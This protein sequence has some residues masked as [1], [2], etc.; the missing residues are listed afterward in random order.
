MQALQK[1]VLE[2][3]PLLNRGRFNEDRKL[4]I[5]ALVKVGG[6]PVMQLLQALSQDQ[7]QAAEVRETAT[8][9]C[10]LLRRTIGGAR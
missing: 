10:S 7:R 2:K 9:A 8:Q 6:L 1:V 5:D 4:L 3:P